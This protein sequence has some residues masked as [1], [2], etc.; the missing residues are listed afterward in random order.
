MQTYGVTARLGVFGHLLQEEALRVRVLAQAVLR[1]EDVAALVPAPRRRRRV[2]A[3][4]AVDGI[5]AANR[6][7]KGP[8]RNRRRRPCKIYLGRARH[9]GATPR[10]RSDAMIRARARERLRRRLVA[11]APEQKGQRWSR[12]NRVR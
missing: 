9:R 7:R 3:R 2:R 6:D 8:R 5:C 10:G 1:L 11:C 12:P 4:R